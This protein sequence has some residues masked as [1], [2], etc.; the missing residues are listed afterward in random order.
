LMDARDHG[1]AWLLALGGIELY[2]E[3][4]DRDNTT[5]DLAGLCLL[6]CTV[7]ACVQLQAILCICTLHS[8]RLALKS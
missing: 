7:S 4:L 6:S 3:R 2:G 5:W 8:L 1:G